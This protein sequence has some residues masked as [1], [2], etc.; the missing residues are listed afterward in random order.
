MPFQRYLHLPKEYQ[1][2]SIESC[3]GTQSQRSLISLGHGRT[4]FGLEHVGIWVSSFLWT[5]DS[6]N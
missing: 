4:V 6:N 1:L 2:T 5:D 3:L